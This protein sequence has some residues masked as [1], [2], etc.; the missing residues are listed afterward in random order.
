MG[1]ET[2]VVTPVMPYFLHCMEIY[3]DDGM[4]ACLYYDSMKLV[5]QT[6]FG[7]WEEPFKQVKE[8]LHNRFPSQKIRLVA[9]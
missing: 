2:W 3:A 4:D 9:S 7:T 6:I 1:V 5:R 8:R